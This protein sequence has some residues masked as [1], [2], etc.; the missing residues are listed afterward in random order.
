M[1]LFF[2]PLSRNLTLSNKLRCVDGFGIPKTDDLSI[3]LRQQQSKAEQGL[4]VWL[5]IIPAACSLDLA[6]GLS[7]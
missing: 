4:L 7:M 5:N 6:L 1:A 2:P 3:K